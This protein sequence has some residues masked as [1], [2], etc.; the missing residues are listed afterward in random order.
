MQGSNEE[1]L[2]PSLTFQGVFPLDELP[3]E[4]AVRIAEID[5][6][7]GHS[8]RHW[9]PVVHELGGVSLRRIGADEV[10]EAAMADLRDGGW[11]T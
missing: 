10:E 4:V 5:R 8:G 11:D 1:G 3:V 7:V 2:F 9:N 6:L